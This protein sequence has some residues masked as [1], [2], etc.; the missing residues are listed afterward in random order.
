M[1]FPSLGKENEK[2]HLNSCFKWGVKSRAELHLLL[3]RTQDLGKWNS[4]RWNGIKKIGWKNKDNRVTRGNMKTDCLLKSLYALNRK[5]KWRRALSLKS[6]YSKLL[7]I[8]FS[9]KMNSLPIKVL[10]SSAN[11]IY[12]SIPSI[13]IK[14]QI[15]YMQTLSRYGFCSQGCVSW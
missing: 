6:R 12:R 15:L 13:K 4:H 14:V 7:I 8:Q 1:K 10:N 2:W 5:P 3:S 11:S 9:R